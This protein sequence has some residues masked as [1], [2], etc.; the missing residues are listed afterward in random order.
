MCGIDSGECVLVFRGGGGL[1][2]EEFGEIFKV[3]GCDAVRCRFF[4]LILWL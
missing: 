4:F 3:E 1:C 2:G